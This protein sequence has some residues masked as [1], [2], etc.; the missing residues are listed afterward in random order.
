VSA[1]VVTSGTDLGEAVLTTGGLPSDGVPIPE[2]TNFL[3][4]DASF[5]VTC[6]VACSVAVVLS[7]GDESSRLVTV[8]M[9]AAGTE[10]GSLTWANDVPAGDDAT[11]TLTATLTDGTATAAGEV[12]AIYSP[13][14]AEGTNTLDPEP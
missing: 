1:P 4:A 7:D 14:G 5:A 6:T 11:L 12:S 9:T 10:H 3:K 8:A 13:F 2:T